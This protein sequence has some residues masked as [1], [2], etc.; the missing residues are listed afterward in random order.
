MKLLCELKIVLENL[1]IV[2]TKQSITLGLTRSFS[3]LICRA[4]CV[5]LTELQC[6]ITFDT[7]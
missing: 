1:Y 6:N 7:F 5:Y 3:T 2:T 4:L